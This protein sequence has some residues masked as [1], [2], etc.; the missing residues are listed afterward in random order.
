[1]SAPIRAVLD[2][3][4][5]RLAETS[6]SPDLDARRL[7]EHTLGVKAAYLIVHAMQALEADT[8]AAFE[9]LLERRI[10]GEPL[11][12][13]VGHV[14]F[15]TLD[16]ELTRDV[17]VPRPDTETLVEAALDRLDANAPLQI[18]DLGTGSG[19]IA[20][21][22]AASRSNWSVLATDESPAAL[23]C[24]RRNAQRL[25]LNN[26]SFVGGDWLAP[27]RGRRFD[28]LLSNPP[29]IAPDDSH[30]SAPALGYEPAAALVAADEGLADL[31]Q[32]TANA[33]DVLKP[34]GWLMLEHGADQARAMR[35]LLEQAGF[36]SVESLP[37]LAGHLRI[38]LGR[39]SSPPPE[40]RPIQAA[41][42][43]GHRG[44]RQ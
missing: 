2:A 11:A 6:D 15:W 42:M 5:Q 40:S 37:D 21:A 44:D 25:A 28:A 7:L 20:L 34:G 9:T 38:T 30:L 33:C 13:I 24:A 31:T 1:M 17:L 12:Y 10:A 3:A 22:L 8:Q 23:D 19:A 36:V 26:V 43:A 32:I 18:A 41:T 16:L 39:R 27:L 29:Y 14:G 35:T 4:R